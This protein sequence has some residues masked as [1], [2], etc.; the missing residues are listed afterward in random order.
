MQNYYVRV[1]EK[2]GDGNG[3][4]DVAADSAEAAMKAAE[5][6]ARGIGLSGELLYEAYETPRGEHNIMALGQPVARA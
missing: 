2:C 4:F 6:Q 5:P 1:I 3:H